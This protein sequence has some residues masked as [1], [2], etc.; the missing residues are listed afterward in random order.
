MNI[1]QGIKH[2]LT[3]LTLGVATLLGSSCGNDI[4]EALLKERA[5]QVDV[6]ARTLRAVVSNSSISADSL[7][8]YDGRFL[9]EVEKK[10]KDSLTWP[11]TNS[12]TWAYNS[13][14]FPSIANQYDKRF[15][16][17]DVKMFHRCDI[18][19]EVANQYAVWGGEVREIP[20]LVENGI[21]AEEALRYD[22]DRFS[23]TSVSDLHR[24]NI[25][26]NLAGEYHQEFTGDD[27]LIL[28]KEGILPSEANPY[29]ELN[30]EFGTRISVED[31]VTF[32]HR[33]ISYETIADRAE[34]TMLDKIIIN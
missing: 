7:V 17:D 34:K 24:S 31:V 19:S 21:A 14:L 8:G 22:T 12:L 3:Y 20:T 6:D 2:G 9:K 5:G 16:L 28:H 10:S 23:L 18:G 11:L 26:G 1:K 25:G 32:K 13:G 33:G 27:I 4:N 30:S 15:S 29:A